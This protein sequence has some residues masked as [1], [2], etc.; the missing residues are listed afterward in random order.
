MHRTWYENA[1]LL[2]RFREWLARTDEELAEFQ[3]GETPNDAS[4]DHGH[5]VEELDRSPLPENF[6]EHRARL[7]FRR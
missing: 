7:F 4:S 2:D 3:A 5:S 1:D 6:I